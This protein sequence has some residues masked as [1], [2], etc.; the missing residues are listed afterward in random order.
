MVSLPIP[1]V[2][3]EKLQC[4]HIQYDMNKPDYNNHKLTV[5]IKDSDR[6]ADLRKKIEEQYGYDSS[7]FLI[8]WVRDN[9]LKTIFSNQQ[10]VKDLGEVGQGV[11]LLFEIPPELKPSLPPLEQVKKDDSNNGIDTQWVKICVHIFKEY[12]GL[13][14]LPRFL[15]AKKS[16]TLR[17]LHLNFYATFSDLFVR[18]YKDV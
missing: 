17:E 9:R 3:W 14:N 18:W 15:W 6:V 7:S 10:T 16:W 12:S 4:Y 13:L 8:T 2:N 1:S 11:L 5:R